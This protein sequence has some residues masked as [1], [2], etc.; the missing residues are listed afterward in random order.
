MEKLL[1]LYV[2]SWKKWFYALSQGLMGLCGLFISL[3][4]L[5]QFWQFTMLKL[6]A[7]LLPLCVWT[8]TLTVLWKNEQWRYRRGFFLPHF[9]PQHGQKEHSRYSLLAIVYWLLVWLLLWRETAWI[10]AWQI[11]GSEWLFQ[12]VGAAKASPGYYQMSTGKWLRLLSVSQ[13]PDNEPEV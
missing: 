7:W 13:S 12:A 3:F 2:P 8:V 6:V 5:A 10:G 9:V 4:L 1:V 11:I